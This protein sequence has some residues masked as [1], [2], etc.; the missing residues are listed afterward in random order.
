V[1]TLIYRINKYRSSSTGNTAVA[2]GV[3]AKVKNGGVGGAGVV[4]V[5]SRGAEVT[6][7]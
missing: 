7:G 3:A 1:I 2:A 4:T 5:P 6:V